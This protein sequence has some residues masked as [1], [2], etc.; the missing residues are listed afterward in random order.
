VE[1]LKEPPGR[2]RHLSPDDERKIVENIPV[3]VRRILLVAC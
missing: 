2:V 3:R 1:K